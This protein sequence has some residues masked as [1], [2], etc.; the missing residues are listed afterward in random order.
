MAAC[1]N[2]ERIEQV[3]SSLSTKDLQDIT[4]ENLQDYYSARNFLGA[5]VEDEFLTPFYSFFEADPIPVGTPEELVRWVQE[6]IAVN[7]DPKAWN[8]PMSPQGVYASRT[9]SPRSRDIFFVSAARALGMDARKDPVTGKVQYWQDGQWMDVSFGDKAPAAVTPKGMLKLSY[10]PSGSVDNPKY[11]S[12]FTLSRLVDGRPQLLSFD[13]GEVDMGGGVDWENVFKE[14]FD[15]DAGTYLLVAGNRLSDGSVP[16]SMTLFSLPEGQVTV[17]ELLIEEPT[18][19]VPVIGSF[20]CES[21]CLPEGSDSEASLLSQTGRGFYIVAVLEPGK[22]PTNHVL[23]DLAAACSQLE[24]WGRPVVLLCED[25]ASLARLRKEMAE[26]R[27]G[28][29]PA[30]IRLGVDTQGIRGAIVRNLQLT[31]PGRLPLVIL[32]DTFN[33]VFFCSEGYTIG[34]GDQLSGTIARL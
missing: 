21:A 5:R 9:A 8:I 13:E 29:L 26:G 3:L 24:A 11:Y 7:A 22:E 31:A 1:G 20:D 16:V 12:L 30:T 19:G 4:L 33:R 27:Y 10:K 28:Q 17:E 15:L 18:G 6:N 2:H 25:S 32:S 23:R 34:L 14:G